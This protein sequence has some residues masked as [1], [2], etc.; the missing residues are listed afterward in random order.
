MGKIKSKQIRKAAKRLTAENVK[1]SESFEKNKKVLKGLDVGKKARN[2][3][4]GLLAKS[5]KRELLASGQ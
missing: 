2:Q 5:K 4:A 1:F 3:I